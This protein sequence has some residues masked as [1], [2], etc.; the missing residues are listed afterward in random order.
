[1]SRRASPCIKET[2][3]SFANNSF[4]SPLHSER[5]WGWGFSF[6][7]GEA[8]WGFHVTMSFCLKHLLLCPCS[9]VTLS[10][11]AHYSV[12]KNPLLC[13][14]K[15]C[16]SVFQHAHKKKRTPLRCPLCDSDTIQTCN[17]LI[18]SQV[19]YSVELRNHYYGRTDN[20][21]VVISE[22]RV[23]RYCFLSVPPNV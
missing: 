16:S 1:M 22:L 21:L 20:D 23:Q 14:Q 18:R 11:K 19:L 3:P 15:I 9:Y 12:F 8:G 10:S 17:L 5:G 7:L 2:P 13:L 4:H 6:P